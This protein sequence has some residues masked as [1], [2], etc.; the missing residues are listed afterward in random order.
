MAD[1]AKSP[2]E[3]KSQN[4]PSSTLALVMGPQGAMGTAQQGELAL[5]MVHPALI[6]SAL[7]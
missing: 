6:D 5:H 3:Q 1:Q 2:N 7:G 4:V